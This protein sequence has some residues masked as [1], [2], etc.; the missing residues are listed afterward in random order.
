MLDGK[1]DKPFPE[2]NFNDF[3]SSC[4]NESKTGSVKQNIS[5]ETLMPSS[6]SMPSIA[7]AKPQ[8]PVK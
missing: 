6:I 3:K 5:N 7:A 2:F 4:L 8:Q 1:I